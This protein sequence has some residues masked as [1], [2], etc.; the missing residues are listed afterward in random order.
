LEENSKGGGAKINKPFSEV[1]FSKSIK[2]CSTYSLGIHSFSQEQNITKKGLKTEE[3]E[4]DQEEQRNH[5]HHL[6]IS[7]SYVL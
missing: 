5:L 4:S 6:S 3:I 2:G 7:S 1:R